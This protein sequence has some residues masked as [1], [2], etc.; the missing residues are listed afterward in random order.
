MKTPT[1]RNEFLE[2]VSLPLFRLMRERLR[3]R[4]FASGIRMRQQNRLQWRLL[5]C[6]IG[7]LAVAGCVR[8]SPF[9]ENWYL[10]RPTSWWSVE[11]AKYHRRSDSGPETSFSFDGILRPPTPSP[12]PTGWEMCV[13]RISASLGVRPTPDPTMAAIFNPGVDAIP[14]LTELLHDSNPRVRIWAVF[15]MQR[16]ELDESVTGL[17]KEGLLQ[18]L[19]TA[20]RENADKENKR[21]RMKKSNQMAD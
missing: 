4:Y 10:K 8:L 1:T 16:S 14:V 19:K 3:R 21:S 2:K 18:I 12:A 6:A 17:S 5:G 13:Y 15:A 11:L 7:V 9:E 20:L